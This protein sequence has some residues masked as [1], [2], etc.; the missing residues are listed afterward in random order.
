[1]TKTK[2]CK[3]LEKEHN[4]EPQTTAWDSKGLQRTAKEHNKDRKGPQRVPN[5]GPYNS[6]TI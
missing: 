6:Q 4:K 1:M 2:Y 3:G 5:S